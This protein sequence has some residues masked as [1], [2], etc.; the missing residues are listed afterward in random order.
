MAV[1]MVRCLGRA[2]RKG[3]GREVMKVEGVRGKRIARG[4]RGGLGQ[5]V[6]SREGWFRRA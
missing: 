2:D 1:G 5:M 6:G 3:E 4:E